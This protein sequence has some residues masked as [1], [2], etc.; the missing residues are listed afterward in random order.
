MYTVRDGDALVLVP[1]S[2]LVP[3]ALKD[4]PAVGASRLRMEGVW[5]HGDTDEP[6]VVTGIMG[7]KDGVRYYSIEGSRTGIPENEFVPKA[8]AV[9]DPSLAETLEDLPA[10]GAPRPTFYNGMTAPDTPQERLRQRM[11]W[12]FQRARQR[13]HDAPPTMGQMT[14]DVLRLQRE[15]EEATIR[16][17]RAGGAQGV[18]NM[19]SPEQRAQAVRVADAYAR[20]VDDIYAASA[21]VGRKMA[22]WGLLNFGQ[23]YLGDFWLQFVMPY[24]HFLTR[25]PSRLLRLAWSRPDLA[26]LV[27]ELDRAVEIENER[28]QVPERL[29]GTIP[30]PQIGPWNR[31]GF[32]GIMRAAAPIEAYVQPNK[33]VR[34]EE[35]PANWYREIKR[36]QQYVP[37]WPMYTWGLDMIAD[38]TNPLAGGEQRMGANQLGDVFPQ[39]RSYGYARG[40]LTGKLPPGAGTTKALGDEFD[41]YRVGRTLAVIGYKDK[42]DPVLVQWA[43]EIVMNEY[44]GRPLEEGIPPEMFD[45]ALR[46]KEQ[47]VKQAMW[48][49]AG[50]TTVA[51]LTGLRLYTLDPKEQELAAL[52]RYYRDLGYDP[53]ENPGGSREQRLKLLEVEPNLASAWSTGDMLP[54]AEGSPGE[55]ARTAMYH[56]ENDEITARMNAA[57]EALID[58][59]RKTEGRDPTEAEMSDVKRPF[60]DEMK[61]LRERYKYEGKAPSRAGMNPREQAQANVEAILYQKYPGKPEYPAENKEAFEALPVEQRRKYYEDLAAWEEKN[62][63]HVE[64]LLS[65]QATFGG[66][67]SGDP[68]VA[69]EFR[70]MVSGQYGSDLLRRFE[71]RFVSATEYAWAEQKAYEREVRDEQ[72]KQREDDVRRLMGN[73]AVAMFGEYMK[74]D[75]DTRAELRQKDWRYGAVRE[76]AYHP[77]EYRYAAAAWGP[78]WY[79]VYAEGPDYPQGPP[80]SDGKPTKPT[81][82]QLDAYY[83]VKN[84]YDL[85]HPEYE[86]IRLWY[87]GRDNAGK[88]GLLREQAEGGPFYERDYGEDMAELLGMWPDTFKNLA[89]YNQAYAAYDASVGNDKN[90]KDP[91]QGPWNTVPNWNL[92]EAN[93]KAYKQWKAEFA[94]EPD[95][96]LPAL[97]PEQM[98]PVGAYSGPRPVGSGAAPILP[99]MEGAQPPSFVRQPGA[100]DYPYEN[101]ALLRGPNTLAGDARALGD[102]LTGPAMAARMPP[103]AAPVAAPGDAPGG[104]APPP[105]SGDIPQ[106]MLDYALRDEK[107]AE[108]Y[109]DQQAYEARRQ[110]AIELFGE[111]IWEI[112]DGY[113]SGWSR[114]EKD[115]YF[116][117]YP[118]LRDFWAWWYGDDGAGGARAQ[119]GFGGGAW[120]G[121][122]GGGGGFSFGDIEP[123]EYRMDVRIDPRHF[124]YRLMPT[125]DDLRAWRPWDVVRLPDWLRTA[126]RFRYQRFEDYRPPDINQGA[127]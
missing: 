77:E 27:Y 74:A 115:A 122:G 88:R 20:V 72:W 7:E 13:G 31:L 56:R 89:I 104:Q 102:A 84:S 110:Q 2:E 48:E 10:A 51:G 28:E 90:G 121:W 50:A 95:K 92:V 113:D 21:N 114:A 65:L 76:A 15:A 6:V 111:D 103:P 91:A 66:K 54:G 101:Q 60:F 85:K 70:A 86:Q 45:R 62:L 25:M 87:N 100:S 125:E 61:A 83:A 49:R 18:R 34:P 36:V 80:G 106:S 96:I 71:N 3:E 37:T 112:V 57:A 82:E 78:E 98:P 116:A 93:V 44:N 99:P 123:G 12:M 23:K 120:G 55:S 124:D 11:V 109:A 9:P 67:W 29:E 40:A 8:R 119:R 39:G 38:Q 58:T 41:P 33:F 107:F 117:K 108:R 17:I 81:Q 1:G 32:A 126:D 127:R 46:L 30:I 68:K 64:K 5:R 69:A 79:K 97:P 22:D 47:G 4:W 94:E 35:E 19:L 16:H 73:E 75:D 63:A 43:Q 52:R 53:V 105:A 24:S 26:N 118:Q 59:T 42:L 14:A